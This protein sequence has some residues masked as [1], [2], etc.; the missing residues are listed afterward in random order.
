MRHR[1]SGESDIVAIL[2]VVLIAAVCA[3]GLA[4]VKKGTAS[5]IEEALI[6]ETLYGIKKVVPGDCKVNLDAAFQWPEGETTPKLLRV[7]YPAYHEDGSLCAMA[8][9]SRTDTGYSGKVV[10]LA[11]FSQLES[12][13]SL[14]LNR[15][16]VIE[17]AE[18][19]GLGSN[20]T[21]LQDAEVDTWG[22]DKSKVFGL[23]FLDK[24]V[25][26]LSFEVKKTG[27][28]DGD[29]AGITAATISSKAV[30]VAVQDA[31]ELV[32]KELETFKEKF[33]GKLAAGAQ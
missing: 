17:H 22:A 25:S 33:E 19:P 12:P 28:G 16:F 30:T 8:V 11:G 10:V 14:K 20:I 29:V 9:R 32:K 4:L 18:T 26:T 24:E 13:A 2:V 21:I 3:A 27:A 31:A 1:E 15:I 5:A 6:Q 7:V 23:N